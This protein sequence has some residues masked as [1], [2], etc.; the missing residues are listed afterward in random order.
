MSA[1][2]ESLLG[3]REVKRLWLDVLLYEHDSVRCLA[4]VFVCAA[5]LKGDGGRGL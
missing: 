1:A 5:S 3:G 4:C 2:V